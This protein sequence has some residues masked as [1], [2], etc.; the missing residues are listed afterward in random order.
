LLLLLGAA[1]YRNDLSSA[2]PGAL[3]KDFAA[4]GGTFQIV[5]VDRNKLLEL[6]GVPLEIG[7]ALFGPAESAAVD[8]RAKVWG[9]ASGRRFPEFGVGVGDVG[10]YRL[11]LLPVQKSLELR[12]RDEPLKS[13]EISSPWKSGAWTWLRLRVTKDARGKWLAQGKAWPVD[14][15]EPKDWQIVQ[16]LPEAPAAGRASVWAVP[17]SGQPIRFD[18]LVVRDASA[19]K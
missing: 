12:R 1:D 10:G 13:A 15:A 8:V 9:T 4:A 5:E 14:A 11:M 17:F 3:P 19:E 7:G 18:D 2:A 6:P 16:E